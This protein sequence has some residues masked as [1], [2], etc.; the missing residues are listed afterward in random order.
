MSGV[1]KWQLCENFC[2]LLYNIDDSHRKRLGKGAFGEVYKG[3]LI[4]EHNNPNIPKYIAVK[5]IEL[6]HQ[7]YEETELDLY[8]KRGFKFKNENLVEIF[9]MERRP[10]AQTFFFDIYMEFCDDTLDNMVINEKS[11]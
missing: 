10:A 8:L 3:Q 4:D 2:P 7:K 9:Y 1:N 11:L 6:R 5:H